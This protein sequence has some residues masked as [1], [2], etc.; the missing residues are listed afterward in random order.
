MNEKVKNIISKVNKKFESDVLQIGS[1][2]KPYEVM[3]TPFATLTSLIGGLPYGRF[4]TVAGPEHTGKGA[5]CLQLI[6]HQQAKDPDFIALWTDAESSFEPAW[7]Q[8]LG[9]DLDRLIVQRYTPTCDIMESLL[10]AGLNIIKE[11]K[12]ISLWVIDSIGALLPKADV[13]DSKDQDKSLEGMKMLN[14][15]VKMGE[16][17]RKANI[18]INKDDKA[19]YKGCAV[20]LIGQIY[21]VPDA[22]VSLQEVRGG[23]SVKHWAHLRLILRRGPKSEWPE[24]IEQTGIDGNKYK[25]RLGWSG[26]FKVE[27]TRINKNEGKEIALDFINGKGFD[28]FNATINAA[29]GL[30][31]ITRAG[32]IYTC[33]IFPEQKWKGRETVTQHFETNSKDFETLKAACVSAALTASTV[34][35]PVDVSEEN[36]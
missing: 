27:K 19:N 31:L 21:T 6:A 3:D 25:V 9:V 36:I 7:A 12:G 15:Q 24:P 14:L 26:R 13:Y 28:S 34:T 23:N 8:Q 29:F 2:F 16:F 18:V 17:Y 33:S 22:Q 20:I 35:S 11:T 4:T 5:F 10:D 32:A 1:E 30:G